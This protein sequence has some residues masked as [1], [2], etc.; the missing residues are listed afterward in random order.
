MKTLNP[1]TISNNIKKVLDTGDISKMTN[2]TYKF[3]M[4][5]SGFI[6]HTSFEGFKYE[7]SNTEK[8]RNDLLNSLDIKRPNYYID[9]PFFQKDE[10]TKYYYTSKSETLNAIKDI[11]E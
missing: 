10:Q 11:L 4:I 7:Y 8:L 5:L 9:D 3:V 1:K 6:A 2:S